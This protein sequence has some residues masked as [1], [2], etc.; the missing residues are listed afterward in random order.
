MGRS[1]LQAQARVGSVHACMKGHAMSGAACF[2][3]RR[4]A[5]AVPPG[6]NLKAQWWL[7]PDAEQ[8][9]RHW[10]RRL[11]KDPADANKSGRIKQ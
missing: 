7:C 2:F 8:D 6:D 11:N 1:S 10:M 3:P 5:F 4:H 9:T